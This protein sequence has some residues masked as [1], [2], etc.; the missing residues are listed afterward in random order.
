MKSIQW[1]KYKIIITRLI[2]I[3]IFI[4]YSYFNFSSLMNANDQEI[5][6][7]LILIL[8]FIII[9]GFFKFNEK[10]DKVINNQ[11]I[12]I[13]PFFNKYYLKQK[14]DELRK[15]SDKIIIILKEFPRDSD[16]IFYQLI[17]LIKENKKIDIYTSQKT[18]L[19]EKINELLDIVNDRYNFNIYHFE[20]NF[21]NVFT[22]GIN[23]KEYKV[24]MQYHNINEYQDYNGLYY[25]S[26]DAKNLAESLLDNVNKSR[27]KILSRDEMN[28]VIENK[29][30]YYEKLEELKNGIPIKTVEKISKCMTECLNKTEGYLYVTHIAGGTNTELFEDNDDFKNWIKTNHTAA[31]ERNVKIKR[32]IILKKEDLENKTIQKEMDS[33]DK[34]ENIEVYYCFIHNL[35]EIFIKDFS[36]YDG[37]Y[38]VYI[39]PTNNGQWIR[40]EAEAKLS[41][42]KEIIKQYQEYFNTIKNN[43]VKFESKKN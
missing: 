36:I 21:N 17:K 16:D 25:E 20:N 28:Y 32:I 10:I 26:E 5:K 34:I 39:S 19:N 43:A 35:S 2:Y 41:V 14:W 12:N 31:K 4:G 13:K 37:R 8:L 9:D 27:I 29:F 33:M 24:L 42:D 1:D 38:L 18:N 3:F 7:A 15:N 23:Q 6:T 30:Q 22:I 40:D 11:K